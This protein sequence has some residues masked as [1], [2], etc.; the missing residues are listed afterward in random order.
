MGEEQL[1]KFQQVNGVMGRDEEG[2]FGQAVNY[3]QDHSV[4]LRCW[5]LFDEVHGDGF[6]WTWGN[7]QLFEKTIQFVPVCLGTCT[8]C[9]GSDVL[10]GHPGKTQPMTR[11]ADQ[12]DGFVMAKMTRRWMVMVV[13][14]WLEMEWFRYVDASFVPQVLL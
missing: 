1:G 7:W 10:F 9:T 3:Y 4:S 14:D 11:L 6:P 12:V 13:A 5:K 2:L 8:Y